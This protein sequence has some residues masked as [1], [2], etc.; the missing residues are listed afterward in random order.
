METLSGLY[1][2]LLP[3]PTILELKEVSNSK[4][5]SDTKIQNKLVYVMHKPEKLNVSVL[6]FRDRNI[7]V[8]GCR[9]GDW[10]AN[11]IEITKKNNLSKHIDKIY[12]NDLDKLLSFVRYVGIEIIQFYYTIRNNKHVLYDIRTHVDKFYSCGMIKDTCTKLTSVDDIIECGM[13]NDM[14]KKYSGSGHILKPSKPFFFAYEN[15]LHLAYFKL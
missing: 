2:D 11:T 10:N 4:D 7:G 1:K 8:I 14:V 9:F 5:F 15:T 12:N 3:Y 6:I 13:Y